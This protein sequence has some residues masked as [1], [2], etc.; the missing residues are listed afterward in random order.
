MNDLNQ[1]KDS[2]IPTLKFVQSSNIVG[3]S[4][5][6]E[7]KTLY[8]LFGNKKA[9]MYLNVEDY[10][11]EFLIKSPSVGAYLAR[12]IKPKYPASFVF[13]TKKYLVSDYKDCKLVL[14]DVD[15]GRG[16]ALID[17]VKHNLFDPGP[18][19]EKE[20]KEEK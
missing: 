6:K 10:D 13:A 15:E 1:F 14:T 3:V 2:S 12:H 9:Y 19:I 11:Y 5:E 17:G 18:K 16:Y 4:Y 7:T 8:V 20:K